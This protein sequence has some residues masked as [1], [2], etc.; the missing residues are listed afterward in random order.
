VDTFCNGC[1]E[2]YLFFKLKNNVL[3]KII[4]ELLYLLLCL[5]RMTKKHPVPTERATVNLIKV[6]SWP[7]LLGSML[8]VLVCFGS[9]LVS[10][11]R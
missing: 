10:V 4:E 2:V 6:K 8:L 11:L 9:C 1:F 5:F 7:A 3:L